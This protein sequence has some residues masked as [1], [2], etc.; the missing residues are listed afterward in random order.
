M[1]REKRACLCGCGVLIDRWDNNGAERYFVSGHQRRC[2]HRPSADALRHAYVD[3][4][5]SAVE[6]ARIYGVA[7]STVAT[8]L[9]EGGIPRRSVAEM[10]RRTHGSTIMPPAETLRDLYIT[11]QLS[12][13]DIAKRYSVRPNTARF[14]LE[15][16]GIKRRSVSEAKRLHYG[17]PRPSDD[18]LRALYCDQQMSAAQ[19]AKSLSVDIATVIKW[20]KEA[21]IQARSIKE[22]AIISGR[23]RR[24]GARA[25]NRGVTPRLRYLVLARDGFKCCACG[26]SPK[27]HGVVLHVDHIIP[28][29]KGGSDEIDNLQSLC[30]DCNQGKAD[31]LPDEIRLPTY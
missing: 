15:K 27:E 17:L 11:Q 9:K 30:D 22:A 13:R 20:V 16:V 24:R 3:E 26:R 1:E 2:A 10:N 18:E 23:A 6:L 12:T 28:E 5:K 8:W 25:K 7:A 31:L 4:E 19:I 29:S 14:W 21:G